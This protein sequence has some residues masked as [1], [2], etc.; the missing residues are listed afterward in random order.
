[1]QIE[2][3]SLSDFWTGTITVGTSAM[4]LSSVKREIR[5]GVYLRVGATPTDALLSIGKTVT[6]AATGFIVPAGETSPLLYVDDLSKLWLV[7][8]KAGTLVTW[9]AL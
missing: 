4:K 7:S 3:E 8:T 9:F 6:D 5:K 1:M 2:K